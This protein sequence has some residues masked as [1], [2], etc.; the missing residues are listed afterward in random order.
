MELGV[1]DVTTGKPQRLT[2]G[3]VDLEKH[4]EDW[5]V[6]DPSMVQIGL[7]IVGRQLKTDAGILDLLAIDKAGH[8][9]VI[10][11]KRGTVSDQTVTQAIR[12]ASYITE[13]PGKDLAKYVEDYLKKS[14]DVSLASFLKQRNLDMSIFDTDR[15]VAIFVV[16]TGRDPNLERMARYMKKMAAHV[17]IVSF[18]V[19]EKDGQRLLQRHLTDLDAVG[20]IYKPDLD[21]HLST[22]P[23]Q[24][25]LGPAESNSA[26]INSEVERLFKLA[27][28]NGVGDEFRLIY[29]VATRNGLYPRTYKWSIMYAP[30]N[31]RTRCLICAWVKPVG[32]L[33]DIYIASQAFPLFFSVTEADSLRILGED[34]RYRLEPEE[35]KTAAKRIDKL[36]STI[37]KR[38]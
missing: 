35:V 24:N 38:R 14:Q 10:E 12:Y 11:V 17:N 8:W 2:H 31:N 23:V 29:D 3:I 21:I 36:F 32:G 33:F 9:A 37:S 19:F 34:L 27:D 1:W 25:S 20:E 26:S 28:K 18:E 5:V 4:L 6:Y 16:G 13:I 22:Q 7:I 30:P 15:D